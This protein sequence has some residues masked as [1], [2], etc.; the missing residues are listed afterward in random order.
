MGTKK[1][2][3]LSA[4]LCIAQFAFAQWQQAVEQPRENSFRVAFYN[5]E[6]LFDTVA[7]AK[8]RD[9]EYL[10]Q[11][12]KNYNSR[13][14][15]IKVANIA[16]T[17]RAIGG[18]Q[19]PEIVGLAEI[20]NRSVLIDL[21]DHNALQKANYGIVHYDSKD[22]RGIDVALLYSKKLATVL[23]ARPITVEMEHS[24][25]R[26][27]LYAKLL[28]KQS[29]DTLHVFVNHWSSRWGG[30]QASE[31]KRIAAAKTLKKVTDSLQINGVKNILVMGDFN[32]APRDNSL[33]LLTNQTG[34][35]PL[36]NLMLNLPPTRGSHKYKGV[37]DYLD[38]I[39]ITQSLKN[40]TSKLHVRNNRAYVF[41]ADFLST[42]DEKYGDIYPYR[43]WKGSYFTGGFSDHFPV[44]CDLVFTTK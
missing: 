31:Y 36:K 12:E 40:E 20:E 7:D 27:I 24:R 1:L 25:T 22:P 13:K 29:A 23:Y 8:I 42:N 19:A 37:W 39:L 41:T 21:I 32:D 11:S 28:L 17:I 38:Q 33:G 10:P 4:L 18:W 30:K 15:R 26:D 3:I 44:F 5:V 34:N 14:Y 35:L 2:F 43:S 6:N 16:K 9:E